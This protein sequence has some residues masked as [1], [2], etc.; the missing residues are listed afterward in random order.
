MQTSTEMT[1]TEMSSTENAES[2]TTTA[3][4][5]VQPDPTKHF[6]RV[7][8]SPDSEAYVTSL[9]QPDI[10]DELQFNFPVVSHY[11]NFKVI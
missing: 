4:E 10:G 5:I 1:T 8:W 7:V 9:L 2:T 6:G 3:A 11:A